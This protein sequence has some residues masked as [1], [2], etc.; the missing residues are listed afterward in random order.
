MTAR[1]KRLIFSVHTVNNFA[2]RAYVC[3]N[4]RHAGRHGF[5]R[6]KSET[7]SVSAGRRD[8]DIEG[9]HGRCSGLLAEQRAAAEQ[10]QQAQWQQQVDMTSSLLQGSIRSSEKALATS[11]NKLQQIAA[12]YSEEDAALAAMLEQAKAAASR[13]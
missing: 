8:I 6:C 1:A 7:L 3:G 4:A 12:S 5:K 10:R 13:K 2:A 11:Q 9:S